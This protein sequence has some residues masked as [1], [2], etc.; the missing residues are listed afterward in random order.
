MGA[1][2]VGS[3]ENDDA[4]DWAWTL[5]GDED[6]S[7]LRAAFA[8]VNDAGESDYVESNDAACAVAAAEVVA[9]AVGAP[10]PTLPADAQ[11]WVA[12][13]GS[14]VGPELVEA[15]RSSVERARDSSELR[16]LWDDAGA[17]EWLAV[18]DDLRVRLTPAR[19]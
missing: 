18:V 13:R 1:W 7:V 10:G 14:V 17:E 4:L 16:E 9:A 2:G 3:F 8:A 15:A 5:E 6:G 11:A 12:A 19:P